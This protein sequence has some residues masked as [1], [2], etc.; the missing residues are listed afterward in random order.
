MKQALYESVIQWWLSSTR[1]SLIVVDSAG[2]GFPRF[3]DN[4]RVETIAYNQEAEAI[5][6]GMTMDATTGEKLQLEIALER[7]PELRSARLIVRVNGKYVIPELISALHEVPIEADVLLQNEGCQYRA[8]LS[9]ECS[10]LYGMRPA[11]LTEFLATIPNDL[12]NAGTPGSH[13]ICEDDGAFCIDGN[14]MCVVE[15]FLWAYTNR[16]ANS[17]LLAGSASD[18]KPLRIHRFP[19]MSIPE[20]YQTPRSDLTIL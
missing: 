14:A 19:S 1:A 7:A 8:P 2:Q 17:G 3:G 6:R 13:C 5:A 4:P 11:L 10:E 18:G 12:T 9:W 20:E 15:S 16:Y